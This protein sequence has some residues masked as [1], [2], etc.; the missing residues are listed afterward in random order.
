MKHFTTE[1]WIDFVNQVVPQHEQQTMQKHLESGCREC[2]E[3]VQV[4][5]KVRKTAA[6]ERN[7]QPSGEAVRLAKAVFATAAIGAQPARN[8]VVELLFDSLLQPAA[9][10]ARSTTMGPRQMLY[11]AESY[12][13]DVQIEEQPSGRTLI[14]TG[15]LMDVSKP[16]LVSRGARV[17]LSDRRGHTTEMV[18][19]QFGEFRGEIVDSGELELSV[20]SPDQPPITISLRHAL[21]QTSGE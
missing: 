8:P 7:F 19:N 20:F 2:A 6:N 5:Q 17:T 14:V 11:R 4:W 9:M 3:Q 16:E 21:G 13:I 18:T 15:Q 12:Q 10:G 1:E